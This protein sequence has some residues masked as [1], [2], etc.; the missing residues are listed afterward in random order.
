MQ[1]GS[2]FGHLT[3]S[4]TNQSMAVIQDGTVRLLAL[5]GRYVMRDSY[6]TVL[7][8]VVSHASSLGSCPSDTKTHGGAT[9]MT[10]QIYIAVHLTLILTYKWL[11]RKRVFSKTKFYNS[12]RNNF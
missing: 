6:V 7:N 12:V 9:I 4:L 2:G 8:E 5:Y 1:E 3:L 10:F 11:R